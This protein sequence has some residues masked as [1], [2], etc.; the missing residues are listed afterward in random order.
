MLIDDSEIL[1]KF[2][3]E[4]GRKEAFGL[5]IKKYQEKVYWH[6]RRMVIDHDDADDLVQETFIKVWNNLDRF[7]QDAQLYSWIYRIASNECLQFLQ[8]KK[9]RNH[10]SIDD[11]SE[12]ISNN[13]AAADE[14][15]G[16]QIQ[17]KLQ[18]AIATLPEKQRLVFHMKYFEEMKYEEISTVL[19]TSV[20][21]LK[22][23][24]HL[25]VKKIEEYLS[26]HD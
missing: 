3:R 9:K 20:G 5:L 8:K 17:L 12:Q 4:S 14:L 15:N 22:A 25:A 19:G 16:E 2:S 13:L 24:F 10:S 23:S 1:E 6:C 21:A 18:Q 11:L 26:D 7:R